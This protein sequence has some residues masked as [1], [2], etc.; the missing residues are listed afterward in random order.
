MR[1]RNVPKRSIERGALEN[2]GK[3]SFAKPGKSGEPA[4]QRDA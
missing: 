2:P 3:R 4:D 1:M